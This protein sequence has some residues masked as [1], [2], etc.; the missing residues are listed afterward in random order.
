VVVLAA[1][2]HV[3]DDYPTDAA[4]MERLVE[5]TRA[6]VA[7]AGVE[8]EVVRGGELALDRLPQLDDDELRRFGL[9]G[10]RWLLLETPYVGW[11]LDLADV[12]FRLATR[13]FRSMLAHPERNRDVQEN[14]ERL[15][16]LVDAGTLVQLTAASVDGRLGRRAQASS[17][18][19]LERGL[20]HLVA[21]DAHTADVREAGMQAAVDAIDDADL[22][23]W[24]TESVPGAVVRG[25]RLPERPERRRSRLPWRR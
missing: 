25:E 6:A 20:A 9:A 1:T 19:L 16:P 12:V 5:E 17:M 21:S 15:R 22:A 7:A 18:R 24:L 3:R 14:P 8:M 13:G 11:P 23:R 10:S 2:P 4:T